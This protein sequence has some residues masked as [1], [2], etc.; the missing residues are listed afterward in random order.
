MHWVQHGQ[1]LRLRIIAPLGLGTYE[2]LREP[3]KVTLIDAENRTYSAASPEQLLREA[4]GWRLP[5]SNIEY[6]VRGILAPDAGPSQLNLDDDGLLTDFAVQ[7][8]RVS[9]LDYVAVEGLPMP[10][11]LFM[12]YDKAKVRLVINKWELSVDEGE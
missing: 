9:V 6:W 2:I 1:S 11:K 8:W 12:N 3:D 7:G 10:R 5:I 4:T